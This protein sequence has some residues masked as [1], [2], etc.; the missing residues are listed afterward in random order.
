[1]QRN[2]TD[3]DFQKSTE[4]FL[5]FNLFLWAIFGLTLG[6]VSFNLDVITGGEL[7]KL[8]IIKEQVV[9]TAGTIYCFY[10]VIRINNFLNN[11]LY[12]KTYTKTYIISDV[13]TGSVSSRFL[14]NNGKTLFKVDTKTFYKSEPVNFEELKRAYKGQT[15]EVTYLKGYK[16]LVGLKLKGANTNSL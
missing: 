1:M 9:L 14:D 7:E 16:G 6:M 2:L 10:K 12:K 4:K 15:C 11:L 13:K 8:S 3:L 5:K